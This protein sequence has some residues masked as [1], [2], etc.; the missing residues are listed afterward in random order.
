MAIQRA[1]PGSTLSSQAH[2]PNARG[3]LQCYAAVQKLTKSTGSSAMLNPAETMMRSTIY[4]GLASVLVMA[5]V[6]TAG[7]SGKSWAQPRSFLSTT[8]PSAL[9]LPLR[10]VAQVWG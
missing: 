1:L 6:N 4:F 8:L 2:I 9:L 10:L 5:A 3:S 7:A